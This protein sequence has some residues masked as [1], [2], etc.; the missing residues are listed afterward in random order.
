MI[1]RRNNPLRAAIVTTLLIGFGC[2]PGETESDQP[3]VAVTQA[4][5]VVFSDVTSA[6]GIAFEHNNGRSGKKWLPETLGSGCAFLDYD[7]DGL[8][9]IFLI[10]SRPWD[11]PADNKTS[12]KLYRNAGDGTFADATSETGLDFSSYGLGVAVGDYDNDGF[13][14]LYLT[15]LD[16]D[17]LL[18]NEGGEQFRD[19]SAASGITNK[20]FGTSVAFFDYD[21]DGRLDIFVDNYVAWSRES[22]LWCTL[23]GDNKS[24]CTPESYPGVAARLYRNLGDGKFEDVAEQ[25]GVADPSSKALGTAILDFDDDGLPD[26]FQANDTEP[27]KL[28]RNNGDGTFTNVG[29][30]AGVALAED[31]TA[32]GAMGVAA[33]DYDRS[34]R[35]HL[36]V[37]NFSNEMLNLFH[38]E[39]TGLFIDDA[40][41]SEVGRQSLL[42]LTFGT[43]FFDYDLDSYLDIFVAN[44]HLEEEIQKVQPKV[45]YAQPPQLFRNN[46]R[47]AFRLA[48]SEIG[49]DLVRPIVARGAAYGDYDNDG[50]LDVLVT[51]NNGPAYLFRNDGGN[52]NSYLRLKLQG[53]ESNRNGY[54]T[55]V[56]VRAPSGE[57]TQ[58]LSSGSS[59][60]S[61][62]EAVLTFGLSGDVTVEEAEIVW[63]SGATQRLANIEPNRTWLA[64]EKDGLRP[65][66]SP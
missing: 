2:M 60:C 6:A 8:L 61:A 21:R 48:N 1:E 55:K 15:S 57:Q 22:D 36:L 52:A 16:G 65:Y 28:Y 18:H 58:T 44:G 12:S 14:D 62:S 7:N 35:P 43:F 9:D 47:G 66:P 45:R 49:E 13:D 25:A 24:Y 26:I 23:D 17:R 39:G 51:T 27:N 4:A 37:G 56:T 32:R 11:P 20:A 63:P 29:I 50:D 38:N 3:T 31:G 41:A 46:G 5:D 40:P 54:G 64:H 59:Y 33:A 30:S 10:N 42:T 19:V 34:G 53:V